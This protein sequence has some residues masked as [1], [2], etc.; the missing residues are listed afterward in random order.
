MMKVSVDLDN[1][2]SL[3]E[4][5]KEDKDGFVH[6]MKGLFKMADEAAKSGHLQ[7]SKTYFGKP[8]EEVTSEVMK[9]FF[10]TQGMLENHGESHVKHLYPIYKHALHPLHAALSNEKLEDRDGNVIPFHE[11]YGLP[12]KEFSISNWIKTLLFWSRYTD[13]KDMSKALSLKNFVMADEIKKKYFLRLKEIQPAI[14]MQEKKGKS[15]GSFI[16]GTG[17][18]DVGIPADEVTTICIACRKKGIYDTPVAKG[19]ANCAA[20]YRKQHR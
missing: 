2:P 8:Y 7:D 6:L 18:F 19:C 1:Y 5:V 9:G 10:D 3:K 4:L 20:G 14:E 16:P 11:K 17:L 13:M 15:I 12:E